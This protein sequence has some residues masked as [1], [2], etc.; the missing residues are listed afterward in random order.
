MG[1]VY[2]VLLAQGLPARRM[3]LV[4]VDQT[5]YAAA[6]SLVAGRI[7]VLIGLLTLASLRSALSA[8]AMLGRLGPS[9]R[10]PSPRQCVADP[11]RNRRC[12]FRR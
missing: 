7:V 4:I 11:R 1:A 8:L 5:R 2:V 6:G 3:Q 10:R 9:G 12:R